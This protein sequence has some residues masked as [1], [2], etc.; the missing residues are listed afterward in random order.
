M[1]FA[2]L[3]VVILALGIVLGLA[4]RGTMTEA[5][6]PAPV[7]RLIEMTLPVS[8]NSN[9]QFPLV[10]TRDCSQVSVAAKTALVGNAQFETFSISLDGTTLIGP[11]D[12]FHV[13]S[14]AV[15]G[16]VTQ[17]G[18]W[19]FV[20]VEVNNPAGANTTMTLSIWCAP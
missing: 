12:Q 14:Q 6:K 4:V 17:L 16:A 8:G 3:A 2:A 5:A 1:K 10:D 7:G 19:P 13:V 11:M 20:Q 15:A 9:V 18:P